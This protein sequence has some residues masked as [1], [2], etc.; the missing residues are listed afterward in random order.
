MKNFNF[1]LLPIF[2]TFIICLSIYFF[3]YL[4]NNFF[5][6]E[7]LRSVGFQ[8]ATTPEYRYVKIKFN[9]LFIFLTLFFAVA[10][11][12]L[13]LLNIKYGIYIL[14]AIAP[15]T[16][17]VDLIGVYAGKVLPIIILLSFLLMNKFKVPIVRMPKEITIY[18]II[19]TIG[20]ITSTLYNDSSFI[21]VIR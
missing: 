15:L 10:I 12:I 16:R 18:I 8:N 19:L 11:S 4:A 5:E 2:H 21:P 14:L 3:Y 7:A 20:L 6:F 17:Q 1:F 9:L 13:T